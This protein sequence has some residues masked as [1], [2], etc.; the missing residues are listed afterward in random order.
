[1]ITNLSS[2]VAS[3][4]TDDAD[5]VIAEDHNGINC[6]SFLLRNSQRAVE[7][8][9]MVSDRREFDH[10]PWWEQAAM[11]AIIREHA[12]EIRVRTLPLRTFNAPESLWKPGDLVFHAPGAQNRLS[13]IRSYLDKSMSH[14][15]IHR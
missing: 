5:L 15:K 9:K 4:C 11:G 2:D 8:L 14:C 12:C 13:L 10:H 6:G 3:L 1:M 7:F